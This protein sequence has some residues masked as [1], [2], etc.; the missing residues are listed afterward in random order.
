MTDR[1]KPVALARKA[2]RDLIRVESIFKQSDC[3][4]VRYKFDLP[5]SSFNTRRFSDL[6]GISP[7]SPWAA[8]LTSRNPAIGY[9][10][11]F[12]G[13]IEDKR[14]KMN[15]EYWDKGKK[16]KPNEPEPFAESVMQWIGSLVAE[17]VVRTPTDVQFQKPTSYWR[18]RFNLPFK[19]TMGG[20]EVSIE[21]IALRLPRN[22]YRALN[23]F[24]ATTD[25][26]LFVSL[27]AMRQIEFKSFSIEAEVASFNEAIK[28]FSEPAT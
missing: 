13:I 9:H 24:M 5:L 18:S 6:T 11:H 17:P 20:Q 12:N 2:K 26:K 28:I 21:G 1:Q 3:L 7:G 25:D 8:T 16:A 27:F 10:V 15:V 22:P 14:V 23:A 4:S 19:V